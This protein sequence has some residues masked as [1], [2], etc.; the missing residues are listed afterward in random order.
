MSP[1]DRLRLPFR[2][3]FSPS[4]H[5]TDGS[6]EWGWTAYDQSGKVVMQSSEKFPTLTDCIAD[7]RTKGFRDGE[8]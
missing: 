6:I 4:R 8:S 7:A 2:W 3:H 5:A 1:A